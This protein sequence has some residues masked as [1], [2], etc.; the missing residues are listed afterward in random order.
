MPFIFIPSSQGEGSKKFFYIYHQ[1]KKFALLL[2]TLA[3]T[4]YAQQERVAIIQTLD[5]NDSISFNN[6]SFLT[7]KL[8]ETAVNVLP[9]ERYG[10]MT[11]ESIIA[12][13]GSQERAVKVCNESSCLAELGR[14]VSADFVAQ[15]RVGRFGNDLTIKV[16]LYNVRTGNLIG[17]FAGYSK[18]IYGLL[19][20]IDEKAPDLFKKIS[21]T[22]NIAVVPQ[23]EP[24][25]V[26]YQ[27]PQPQ[28]PSANMEQ[29]AK[30]QWLIDKGLAENKEEILKE[31][32][33]LSYIDKAVLYDE[34]EKS[35]LGYAALNFV[36]GF[37]LGSYIQR[38]KSSW[39]KLAIVDVVGWG[40]A[41]AG[42]ILHRPSFNRYSH[43]DLYLGLSSV[44]VL[45][46]GR[47]AGL[48]VPFYHKYTY[49]KALR[50]TL[51]NNNNISLSIDPLIVPRDG[52]P[53]V[54]LAFNVRY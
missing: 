34:N 52:A 1:M 2:L 33:S 43:A 20:L 14:M 18:D 49:N 12:F 8:R 27:P 25:Q 13:L 6:L 9:G 23:Q 46:S 32:F 45:S 19:A 30:I 17:S 41:I 24:Q 16:E 51:N 48:I 21:S 44:F 42:Q 37:G 39:R 36:P 26:Q 3:L 7:D 11:T 35:A 4:T 22:S 50:E 29:R 28:Q 47:I 10:V 54:G 53:A 15:G 40:L 31:S 5:N 38:D